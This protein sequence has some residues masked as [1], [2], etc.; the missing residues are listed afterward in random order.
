[1][2]IIEFVKRNQLIFSFS[3]FN[4]ALSSPRASQSAK[5]FRL[6]RD[7]SLKG[8][9]PLMPC[10]S[11]PC[12][13]QVAFFLFIPVY[14]NEQT[15]PTDSR[16]FELQKEKYQA[17][18]CRQAGTLPYIGFS[19]RYQSHVWPRLVWHPTAAEPWNHTFKNVGGF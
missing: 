4:S 19:V 3:D 16:S 9:E 17:V 1:M 11:H 7:L 10:C 15:A 6:E 18:R 8:I 13:D 12:P 2:R 5:T 14:M